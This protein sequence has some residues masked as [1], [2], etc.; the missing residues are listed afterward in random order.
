MVTATLEDIKTITTIPEPGMRYL[1]VNVGSVDVGE[2]W[3]IARSKGF[4][5]ELVQIRFQTGTE[6]HGLLWSGPIDETPA[7]IEDT[8]DALADRIENDAIR[9]ASG[10][11]TAV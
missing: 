1:S 10:A 3:Q 7:Q 2:V 9:Y 4:T 11:W 6:I 8:L 5:P